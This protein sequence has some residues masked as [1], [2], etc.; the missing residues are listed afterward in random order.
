MSESDAVP[1]SRNSWDGVNYQFRACLRI[2]WPFFLT[3]PLILFLTVAVH[4]CAHAA[5]VRWQGGVVAA[6]S[7]WPGKDSLGYVRYWVPPGNT[8][9]NHAAVGLAPYS[10]WLGL[11]LITLFVSMRFRPWSVS[12]GRILFV[13]FF[14]APACDFLN[15]IYQHALGMD[16]DFCRVFGPPGEVPWLM[17]FLITIAVFACGYVI[18][19]RFYRQESLWAYS[20]SAFA[21]TVIAILL[22]INTIPLPGIV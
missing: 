8:A 20:Y 21:L 11:M 13:F 4:E 16:N 19:R 2:H 6:W 1:P 3:S 7:F 17:P 14:V 5:C 12:F 10:L 18:Q 22:A 15:A 9:F